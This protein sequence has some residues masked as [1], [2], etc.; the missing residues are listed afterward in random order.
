MTRSLNGSVLT[1]LTAPQN[2]T[3][4]FTTNFYPPSTYP[5]TYKHST[6]STHHPSLHSTPHPLHLT[7]STPHPTHSTPHPT[8]SHPLSTAQH[9]TTQQTT[10]HFT[11]DRTRLPFS[12]WSSTRPGVPI[13]MS[14]PWH[15][16]SSVTDR[17]TDRQTVL[18]PHVT[19]TNTPAQVHTCK[20]H[21]PQHRHALHNPTLEWS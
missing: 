17:Q 5:T 21:T 3:T 12:T 18:T 8:H 9:N 1:T 11:W 2:S 13:K 15:K 7:H 20:T 10:A 4:Q 19:C 14:S 6:L 16:A